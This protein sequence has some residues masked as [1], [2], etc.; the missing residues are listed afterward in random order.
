MFFRIGLLPIYIFKTFKQ[1]QE[2]EFFDKSHFIMINETAMGA[3][4]FS[5]MSCLQIKT[6]KILEKRIR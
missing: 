2:D 1:R 5:I 3:H 4:S 6:G